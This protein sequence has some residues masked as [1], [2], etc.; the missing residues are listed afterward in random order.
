MIL[1]VVQHDK[2][3]VYDVISYYYYSFKCILLQLYNTLNVAIRNST[4]YVPRT[5]TDLTY[6]YSFYYILCSF[7]FTTF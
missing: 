7:F 2:M 5:I 3:I 1:K 4:F 6:L